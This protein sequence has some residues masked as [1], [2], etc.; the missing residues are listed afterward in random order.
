VRLG[1]RSWG[2][3]GG[4]NLLGP[5]TWVDGQGVL[6]PA[7]LASH[8]RAVIEN[9]MLTLATRY[10]EASA[11]KPPAK[12]KSWDPMIDD[13]IAADRGTDYTMGGQKER[14]PM[15]AGATARART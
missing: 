15:I 4:S 2:S 13:A 10:D 1:R 5:A 8:L 12:A 3:R 7:Y 14:A 6:E 9:G 11:S